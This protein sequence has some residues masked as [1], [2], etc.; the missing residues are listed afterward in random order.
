MSDQNQNGGG[1]FDPSEQPEVTYLN[2]DTL[3]ANSSIPLD[4]GGLARRAGHTGESYGGKR[5][6][7]EALGYPQTDELEF[8]DFL[9]AYNRNPYAVPVVDLP[10]MKTWSERPEVSDMADVDG[11]TDFEKDVSALF[12]GEPLRRS[13]LHRLH[14]ADRMA[15]L[16]EYSLIWFS[17]RDGA[18]DLSQPLEDGSLNGL[19]DIV[20]IGVFDQRHVHDMETEGDMASERFGLPITY[21]I[22]PDLSGGEENVHTVHH[23]RVVHVPGEDTRGSDLFSVPIL[24]SGWNTFENIEK[25]LGASAEGFWRGAY[26]GIV[27]SRNPDVQFSDDGAG[28]QNQVDKYEHG[29]R[30]SLF[31]QGADVKTLTPNIADPSGHMDEQV[32]A[33]SACYDI[34][35]NILTGNELGERATS[36]DRNTFHESIR[37][38]QLHYAGPML[39]R[40]VFDWLTDKG[41]VR[42]PRGDGYDTEWPALSEVSEQEQAEIE[43]TRAQALAKASGGTP[44][45][46]LSP[47]EIRREVFDFPAKVGSLLTDEDV[48]SIGT[49]DDDGGPLGPVPE[50]DDAQAQFEQ[51]QSTA[52]AATD[53]GEDE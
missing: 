41:G 35:Q 28:I 46:L 36:E 53:G 4:R 2:G 42:P 24:R 14:N 29:M 12:D 33:L 18:N 52:P 15:R 39:L 11:K 50:G 22:D 7:Y 49:E 13:L 30:R 47:E 45:A 16:G 32:N 23:S 21:D 37:S 10:P 40:A 48:A 9:G 8:K 25:L 44:T 17:V 51:A 26:P 27:V 31:P 19:D 5:D 1:G 6:R 34:P 20:Y 43:H 3:R 38:R